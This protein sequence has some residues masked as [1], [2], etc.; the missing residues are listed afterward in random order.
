MEPDANLDPSGCG[1]IITAALD[2]LDLHDVT[3]V[4][5]DSGGAYSQVAL[6]ADDRRIG[7][8]VLTSCET[9][10]D[11]FPPEPFT[12]LP[13]LACDPAGLRQVLT[14]LRSRSARRNPI[15]FG[16]LMR[17]EPDVDAED[18]YALPALY[19]DGVLHDVAQVM[20]AASTTTLHEAAAMVIESFGRPVLF[21]WPGADPVF[22]IEHARNYAALL[23][24]ARIV[25]VADS[26]GFVAEDQPDLLATAI[27][28]FAT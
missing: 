21:V 8:L 5:S 7:R 15:A 6:A 23:N 20:R 22:P 2:A 11:E 26:Y 28:D 1:H 27:A 12:A 24:D 14:A 10:F 17:H 18:S 4:G 16:S 13:E 19:D 25:E 9:P 3:L